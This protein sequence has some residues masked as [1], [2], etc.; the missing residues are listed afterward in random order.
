[1]G[2]ITKRYLTAMG[3]GMVHLLSL[4]SVI[5]TK[6]ERRSFDQDADKLRS[7]WENVGKDMY[8]SMLKFDQQHGRK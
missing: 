4:F 2:K 3:C 6:L 5:F 1:M 7:D 8:R